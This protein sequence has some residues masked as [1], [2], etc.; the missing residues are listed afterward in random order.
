MLHGS[1]QPAQ[2]R[3]YDAL[4]DAFSLHR[5]MIR[6]VSTQFNPPDAIN[7]PSR[8]PSFPH[9]LVALGVLAQTADSLRAPVPDLPPLLPLPCVLTSRLLCCLCKPQGHTLSS[10]PEFLSFNRKYGFMWGAVSNVIRMVRIGR[11]SPSVAPFCSV[12]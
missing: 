10:T 5:F 4:L 9:S 8:A 1:A 11:L 3:D 7:P 12:L 2:V 6:K